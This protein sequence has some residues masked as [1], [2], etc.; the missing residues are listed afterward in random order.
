MSEESTY[1]TTVYIGEGD[2]RHLKAIARAQGRPAAALVREAVAEYTARHAASVRPSSI[3]AWRSGRSDLAENVD[4][5][6][7][8]MGS[9]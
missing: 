7:A 5:L 8:D 2:Y 3:G 4:S 6:L 9:S 1:K